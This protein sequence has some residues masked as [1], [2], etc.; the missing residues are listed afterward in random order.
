[1]MVTKKVFSV[2]FDQAQQKV[3][4]HSHGTRNIVSRYWNSNVFPSPCMANLFRWTMTRKTYFFT[5]ITHLTFTRRVVGCNRYF[6]CHT[7]TSEKVPILS[8]TRF[9]NKYVYIYIY[10]YIYTYCV[11]AR[12]CYLFIYRHFK[13]QTICCFFFALSFYFS[14]I[15]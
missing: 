2:H 11:L 12:T 3:S 13:I 6:C 1:M 4:S 7:H 8:N 14:Q 15:S 9:S 5:G 10:I